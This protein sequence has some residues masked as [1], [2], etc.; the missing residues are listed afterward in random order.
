LMDF[1][2][3]EEQRLFQESV[4]E[5]AR[6]HLAAGALRRA[7]LPEFPFEESQLMAKQGL[8][9]LTFDEADGGSGGT[10][11]D[12]VLAIQEIALVCPRSADV[13]QAGNFGPIRTF[14]EYATPEQKVRWLPRLLAGELVISLC[15]SEPEAGSAVTDLQT[16]ATPE[17]NGFRVNGT[18]V[19]SS[20]SL[21]A[22]LFLVYVRYGPGV[23]GI[24][25]VLIPRGAEGFT[26]GKPTR[27]VGGD[28]WCQLYF[29][30]VYVPP[31]DV[32]LREGGF[33][34]QIAAFNIERIG[35]AA[36]ALAFG[37]HAFNIARE[38]AL[39]HKQFGRELAEFQGIQWKFAEMAAQLEAA[40][41][42]LY[43]VATEATGRLPSVFDTSLA[44]YLCNTAGFF[45]ANEAMQVLGAL[46]Y[47][48]DSLVEYCWRR[49][50]GWQIA[51]GSL[52]MMKNRIAEGVFDRRFSQRLPKTK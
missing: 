27:Y 14:A 33:R 52:E 24:G 18:K 16:S 20:H 45:A 7:H 31:E 36:R 22:E 39:T 2:L 6:R 17:G 28:D 51:G 34:K 41:L 15:M 26:I 9:G 11:F 44:K 38:H 23:E 25:S 50:R 29:D 3:S 5:F 49:T 32:L 21:E 35:N 47:T 12:A 46:G 10:V 19:F 40:Q 42:M 37:R 13:F 48:Q 4:R 43:K 1:Q 8:L 30:N